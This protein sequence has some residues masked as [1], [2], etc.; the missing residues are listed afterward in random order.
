MIAAPE[1]NHVPQLMAGRIP[2][3]WGLTPAQLHDRFW[4]SR[5]VQVVRQGESTEIVQDAELFLLTPSDSLVIFKLSGM[6]EKLAWAQPDLIVARVHDER[7]K[8]Y[9]EH[10]VADKQ[11]RFTRFQRVYSDRDG[12]RGRIAVT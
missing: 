9:S 3:V 11:G 2:T 8:G 4:A 12:R 7:E 10:I 1:N 5:G 6:I